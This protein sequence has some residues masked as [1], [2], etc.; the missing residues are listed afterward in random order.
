[1][2]VFVI[3]VATRSVFGSIFF[4]PLRANEALRAVVMDL[5]SVSVTEALKEMSGSA[6]TKLMLQDP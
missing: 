1:M 6:H 2:N 5:Q 3:F 4:S